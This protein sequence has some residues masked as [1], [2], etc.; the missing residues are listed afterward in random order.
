MELSLDAIYF[1]GPHYFQ[2]SE[3]I[4]AASDLTTETNAADETGS[5]IFGSESEGEVDAE[6]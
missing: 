2:S 4:T 3:D 5:E 1:N 6:E